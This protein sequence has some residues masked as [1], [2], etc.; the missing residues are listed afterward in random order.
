[1]TPRLRP[2]SRAWLGVRGALLVLAMTAALPSRSALAVEGTGPIEVGTEPVFTYP[3][4]VGDVTYT[5]GRG[6]VVRLE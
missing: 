4:P 6:L 3:S 2:P 5:P 1:M